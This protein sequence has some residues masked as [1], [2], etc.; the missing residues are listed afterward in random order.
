M[1][2]EREI[3]MKW[4]RSGGESYDRERVKGAND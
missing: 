4:L 2:E 1:A 3:E